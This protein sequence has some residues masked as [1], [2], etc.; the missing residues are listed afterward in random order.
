MPSALFRSRIDCG[1]PADAAVRRFALC[2]LAE[3]NET[4]C[5][6]NNAHDVLSSKAPTRGNDEHFGKVLANTCSLF[7]VYLG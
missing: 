4:F 5:H 3:E 2:R 7:G 6:K 1:G